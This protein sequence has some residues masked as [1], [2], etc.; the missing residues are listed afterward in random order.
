MSFLAAPVLDQKNGVEFL[1][2]LVD[3]SAQFFDALMQLFDDGLISRFNASDLEV[4]VLLHGHVREYIFVD[5]FAILHELFVSSC[6]LDCKIF[7]SHLYRIIESLVR[8][9]LLAA[10]VKLSLDLQ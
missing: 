5:A 3:F 4:H 2:L 1:P 9:R 10:E 8:L 6:Q 7:I